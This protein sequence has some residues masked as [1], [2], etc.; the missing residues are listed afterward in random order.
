MAQVV[1]IR[2]E[3]ARLGDVRRAHELGDEEVA[4]QIKAALARA[5][6]EVPITEAAQ[7][8]GL[9]RSTLYRVYLRGA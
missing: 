9:D 4:Q 8:L 3:L 5:K 7:L 2:A 1:D 6:G